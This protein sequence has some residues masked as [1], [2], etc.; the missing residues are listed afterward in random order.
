MSSEEQTQAFVK[1]LQEIGIVPGDLVLVHSQM[2]M[3]HLALVQSCFAALV[4]AVGSRGTVAFPTF[5]FDFCEGKTYDELRTPSHMGLLSEMAR[6]SPLARRIYHPIYGFALVGAEADSLAGKIRN[7][8]S[9]GEDSFFGEL[10]RRNG[11]ILIINLLP[12]NCMTFFHHVEEMVGCEYRYM[13]EFSGKV[14]DRN[15]REQRKTYT[16]F[17]RDRENGVITDVAPMCRKL[18]EQGLVRM[19]QLGPW[20]I[21]LLRA[22]EVF[23]A[24]KDVPKQQPELLRRVVNQK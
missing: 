2:G 8:S 1:Q 14:V 18:E 4:S 7:V 19:G 13:K 15:G 21:R 3:E 20:M 10:R 22:P 6:R 23:E 12:E 11:K 17:V 5:N 16:M 9:Y 24:T